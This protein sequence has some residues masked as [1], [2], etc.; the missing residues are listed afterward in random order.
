MYSFVFE[1]DIRYW[2]LPYNVGSGKEFTM[3]AYYEKICKLFEYDESKIKINQMKYVGMLSNRLTITDRRIE[4]F[5]FK[6]I[7]EGLEQLVNY[8]KT[9][10]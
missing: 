4:D 6:P 5:K 3:R 9:I 1:N 2:N 10:K 8:Y 7:N